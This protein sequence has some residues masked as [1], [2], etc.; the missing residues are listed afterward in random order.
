MPLYGSRSRAE[1]RFSCFFFGD[2]E[3]STAGKPD[4]PRLIQGER[5]DAILSWL[6]AEPENAR[7]SAA[8]RMFSAEHL[9]LLFACGVLRR[10]DDRLLLDAPLFSSEDAPALRCLGEEQARR[11]FQAL[12]GALPRMLDLCGA[13]EN[14]FPAQ[15]NL[16][17][18][19]CGMVMDGSMTDALAD[20][21]ALAL[22]RP[23]AS[24]GD[25]LI[26][27][28]ENCP[29][30]QVFSDL[31]LCSWNRLDNGACALQS[32]GDANGVRFDAYRL[33]RL[34]QNGPL[35]SRFR[36]AEPFIGKRTPAELRAWLPGEALRL[37]LEG[38]CDSDALRL[39][40]LFGYAASGAVR[41]PVFRPQDAE[42]IGSV[43]ALAENAAAEALTDALMRMQKD[44][45]LLSVRQGVSP[46]EIAN[47][48][49]HILF[50]C[51]NER[52]VAEGFAA[53]PPHFPGEG[54]YLRSIRI[55]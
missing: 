22:S 6:I 31:L 38:Q 29:E 26:I 48:L 24:G 36:E 12:R 51:V 55:M 18:T 8:S 19:L 39:L 21:G 7:F 10:E 16:Y 33:F 34:M 42:I 28:Y 30:L 1:R 46:P 32:F 41:A 17:H 49:Y 14:G 35:P 9:Q 37:I 53:A 40:E 4:D 25:H 43:S 47:E 5:T 15:V 13:L 23:R 50:G 2:I 20:R 3:P 27:L 54:R 52:L 45:R 44:A 11:V